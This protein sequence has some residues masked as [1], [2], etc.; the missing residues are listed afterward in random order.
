MEK[1]LAIMIG[2]WFSLAG[3]ASGIAVIRSFKG[4]GEDG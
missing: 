3:I 2:L 4:K 1:V